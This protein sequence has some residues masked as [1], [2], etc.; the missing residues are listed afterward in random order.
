MRTREKAATAGQEPC[1]RASYLAQECG[2]FNGNHDFLEFLRNREHGVRLF[3]CYNDDESVPER[4]HSTVEGARMC[5]MHASPA[6]TRCVPWTNSSTGS[7]EILCQKCGGY[8]GRGF[9]RTFLGLSG[10]SHHHD[11]ALSEPHSLQYRRSKVVPT[12]IIVP[13]RRKPNPRKLNFLLIVLYSLE[14]II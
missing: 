6:L 14:P 13:S 10:L 4:A 3:A 1:Q 11:G 12:S 9:I 8:R 5:T 2:N 7:A